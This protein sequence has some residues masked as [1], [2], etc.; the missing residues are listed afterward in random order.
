[1]SDAIAWAVFAGFI[2]L[3][4]RFIVRGIRRGFREGFHLRA[5]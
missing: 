5:P 1:M 3:L 4:T 2:F